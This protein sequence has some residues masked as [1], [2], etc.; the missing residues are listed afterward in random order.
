MMMAWLWLLRSCLFPHLT[1]WSV[2]PALQVLLWILL[3]PVL[4]FTIYW[5]PTRMSCSETKAKTRI[6]TKRRNWRSPDDH[7]V[8]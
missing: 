7:P 5:L 3:P 1:A 2:G 6:S 8:P 4:Q